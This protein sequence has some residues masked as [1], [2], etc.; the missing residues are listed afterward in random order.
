M[1]RIKTY[2]D[3]LNVSRNAHPSVIKA[4]YKTLCQKYHPDKYA[5]GPEEAVQIMKII[6]GAYA[7]LSDSR[8][9]AEHDRW[10]DQQERAQASYEAQ[11]I[12]EI[13]AQTYIAPP[14]P[15]KN[16]RFA[17]YRATIN[18]FWKSVCSAGNSARLINIRT[19]KKLN[20]VLGFI[21]VAGIILT[22]VIVYAPGF[23]TTAATPPD[24]YVID[25]LKK[26]GQ[27]VKQG[28]VVEAL[29]LYLQLAN[30][31][32]A[33]A[34]FH[35]GLIYATGQGIAE[36]DKQAADWFSKAAEQGHME[37]QTKLGF[38]Y[39]TGK[40]VTQNYNTAVYWCYKA[41]T[42]GDAIAQYNLGLMYAKG[43]GV[44]QDDSLAV[45][46][47]SK[48]AEQGHARAQYYLGDMYATGAGVPKDA[49]QAVVLYRKAAK[50]GLEE[51]ITALKQ[52]DH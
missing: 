15:I 10:I 27:L 14:V 32:N 33:D 18:G 43:Q 31:G 29:P 49:R 48:A 13:I 11:R 23:K 51:A 8:K 42:Q 6:N 45:S 46:W 4:A 24:Q 30:Q 7:V 39:A 36:D 26:A 50:Q 12:M 19:F 17:G 1:A 47:Y 25:T 34:Q 21:G 20:W 16:N 35:A 52:F 41:A 38:M 9:R 28:Q 44:A 5:G 2:Y 40:G 3:S 22:A 37:A